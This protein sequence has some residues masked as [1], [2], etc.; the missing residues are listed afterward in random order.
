MASDQYGKYNSEQNRRNAGSD[1]SSM[2]G[3]VGGSNKMRQ[4]T[5]KE[6][7]FPANSDNISKLKKVAAG[8]PDT[9][10]GKNVV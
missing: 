2:K 6:K 9:A 8:R 3:D 1:D 7:Q 4:V 5:P 10:S